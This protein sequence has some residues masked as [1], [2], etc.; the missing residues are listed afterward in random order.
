MFRHVSAIPKEVLNKEKDRCTSMTQIAIIV[1][2]SVEYFPEDNL[3]S[4]EHVGLPHVCISLILIIVQLL[5]Y[6][7][8]SGL[9]M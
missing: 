7:V 5:K 4:P 1:L 8:F 2:F 6:I 9:K 3:K